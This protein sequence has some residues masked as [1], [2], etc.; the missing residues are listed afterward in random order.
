[1]DPKTI[2]AQF[3]VD[4]DPNY[5]AQG[6]EEEV[7]R[8]AFRV[9]IPLIIKG[10]TG[11]GKTRFIE[12][13]ARRLDLPLITVSCHEDL[14]AADLVGRYLFR[15]NETVWQDGPLTLAVRYG[16]ICYLDEIVEAR[17]DT[18]VV[19]HSLT[20]DRRMLY[21]DKTGEV[22]RAHG[23]FM[24][25]L[26]Y[27]PGYQSIVKDLKH[28]TKQRFA[29]L[30]FNHPAVDTETRIIATETGLDEAGSRRLAE[31]GAKIREL[32]GFGLEEGVSTRLLVYVGRLIQGGLRPL[33]ACEAAVS[34]TLT[35]EPEVIEAIG[36]IVRLYFGEVLDPGEGQGNGGTD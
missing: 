29:A 10:P 12:Y 21:I 31:M 8:T 18:T 34:R 5:I 33:D 22:I 14:T 35:E 24:V 6:D 28:S 36:S 3:R 30:N 17:K 20:D 26:S 9:H 1:M 11:C 32:K 2:V 16:G 25:V 27:N 13:M 15:D 7:F 23:D 4:F 19:I